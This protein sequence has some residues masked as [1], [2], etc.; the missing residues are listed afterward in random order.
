MAYVLIH[1]LR[2]VALEYRPTFS[3]H[4]ERRI[5]LCPRAVS[6]PRKAKLMI[7]PYLTW[8]LLLYSSHP[9]FSL[10]TNGLSLET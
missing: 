2:Y 4:Y 5:I 9:P 7:L 1:W 6:Y 8:F 3:P 10:P